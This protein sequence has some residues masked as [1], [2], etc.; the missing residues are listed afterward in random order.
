MF[1][2]PCSHGQSAP[3]LPDRTKWQ[4]CPLHAQPCIRSQYIVRSC[5]SSL[6]LP[7]SCKNLKWWAQVWTATCVCMK[8]LTPTCPSS[9][10][11]LPH[12]TTQAALPLHQILPCWPPCLAQMLARRYCLLALLLTVNLLSVM[13]AP[14][15]SS[16]CACATTLVPTWLARSARPSVIY[17]EHLHPDIHTSALQ[18]M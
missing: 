6:L 12:T 9:T 18:A 4:T 15:G 16:L 2:L 17:D 8:W 14:P 3:S 5:A 13:L 7:A 1:M 10:F 11:P